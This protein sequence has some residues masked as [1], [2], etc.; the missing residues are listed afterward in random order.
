MGEAAARVDL[1]S[2]QWRSYLG[3]MYQGGTPDQRWFVTA[4]GQVVGSMHDAAPVVLQRW[5][6]GPYPSDALLLMVT[7][8]PIPAGT[9]TAV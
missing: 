3:L 7:N 8:K 5:A 6:G 2:V 9:R 1:S 4:D